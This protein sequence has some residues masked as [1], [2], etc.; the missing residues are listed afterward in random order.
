MRNYSHGVSEASLRDVW[1]YIQSGGAVDL[2]CNRP[3]GTT[4]IL[5]GFIRSIN[6]TSYDS[7]KTLMK[8]EAK[9]AKNDF[10]IE[11]K[12]MGYTNTGAC[13]VWF[14]KNIYKSS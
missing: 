10:K 11:R 4:N 2:L 8:N 7:F 1:E 13:K 5:W 9:W 3:N 6:F 12:E 14:K